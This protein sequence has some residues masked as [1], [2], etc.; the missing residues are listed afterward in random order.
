MFKNKKNLLIFGLG[1]YLLVTGLSFAVFSYLKQPIKKTVSPLVEEEE[2]ESKEQ[3]ASTF[4]GPKNQE[5]PINGVY[6]QRGQKE[7]WEKRRPLLVMIENHEDSR[8]QSGL[9]RAD[10]I[11]EAVAEGGIARLMGVFYCAAAVPAGKYDLGPVR[12]ARTY[13]LDWASEYSDYPLYNHVGGAGLCNDPTVN[14]KAKALCQIENY[15]WK[16]KKHWNDLD[17]F[18]L[19]YKLCRREPE[20]TGKTVATEHTMYCDSAALW[21]EAEKRGLTAQ[22]ADGKSWDKNFQMWTF[23]DDGKSLGKVSDISFDFWQGYSAYSVKWV[24]DSAQ[25][26]YKR[27]NGGAA[28]KDFVSGEQL[29]A[30]TVIIQFSKE[31]GPVDEHKHLLYQTIGSGKALVFQDGG[32]V[33]GKWSKEARQSRTEFSDNSGKEIKLNRGVIWIEVLPAG[34]KVDYTEK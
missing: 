9:N 28:H 25:N 3:K 32:V 21:S 33:S 16:D 4:S 5:C 6:Y 14:S 13:F 30:K 22:T 23:K 17:Q 29:T 10:V 8:P 19:S 12:S 2:K 20:R 34:A 7:I 24:F 11:Y 18:A 27:E 26:V 1:L 31:T 15:G